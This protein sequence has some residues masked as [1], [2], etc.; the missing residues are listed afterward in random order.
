[1]FAARIF[2]LLSL[3]LCIL[4]PNL[5]S[6]EPAVLGYILKRYFS[7]LPESL[8]PSS[9]YDRVIGAV[10]LP[11]E[12]AQVAE[13]DNCFNSLPPPVLSTLSFF[14]AHLIK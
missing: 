10:S 3:K 4:Q 12:A 5:S 6:T 7:E 13:L 9:I 14:T 11:N 2:R 1:M 8:I